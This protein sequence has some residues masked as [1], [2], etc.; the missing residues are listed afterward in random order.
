MEGNQMADFQIGYLSENREAIPVLANWQHQEW[1]ELTPNL[2]VQD[3]ATNLEACA[4]KGQVPITF[5]SVLG[6]VVAGCA[7]LVKS[8]MDSRLEL[9]PWLAGVIVGKRYRGRGIGLA[10]CERVVAEARQLGF[11]CIYLFTPDAEAF[12][13]RQSWRELERTQ[14]FGKPVTIMFKGLLPSDP[15][16]EG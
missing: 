10:L 14:Y 4:N 8:D 1:S 13:A 12:Y 3:R 7:S 16:R 15:K 11:D 2:T 5:V 9:S 6:G